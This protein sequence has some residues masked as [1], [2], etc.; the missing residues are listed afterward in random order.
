M[1]YL[2]QYVAVLG[3]YIT[4]NI[5]FVHAALGISLPFVEADQRSG[6]LEWPENTCVCVWGGPQLLLHPDIFIGE[7]HTVQQSVC[8]KAKL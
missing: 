3:L 8:Q 7:A 2:S 4:R 6:G 1:V 5:T